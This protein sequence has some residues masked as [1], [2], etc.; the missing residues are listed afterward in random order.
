MGAVP[1]ACQPWVLA[2]VTALGSV[3]CRAGELV[4]DACLDQ[5]SDHD[6]Q[7]GEEDEGGPLHVPGDV[8]G[9]QA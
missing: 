3:G 9:V 8:I 4:D 1:E 5:G 6:E 2:T 7:A